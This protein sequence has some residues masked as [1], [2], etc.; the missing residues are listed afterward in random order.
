MSSNSEEYLTSA[1]IVRNIC[2]YSK[3]CWTTS[4]Q[5]FVKMFV[6]Q[7]RIYRKKNRKKQDN[8][9]DYLSKVVFQDVCQASAYVQKKN[10]EKKVVAVKQ[11]RIDS[12]Q[13]W[14][15]GA[16]SPKSKTKKKL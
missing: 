14:P 7:A 2:S 16:R 1:A 8:R 3:A 4:A 5:W 13:E 12:Y 6:R 9:L 10:I 11:A 15:Q